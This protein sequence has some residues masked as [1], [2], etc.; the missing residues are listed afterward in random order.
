MAVHL[1]PIDLQI[2]SN[3]T[4]EADRP[5]QSMVELLENDRTNHLAQMNVSL[6]ASWF[7]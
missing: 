4:D 6:S 5:T 3:I 1:N 7:E 2:P